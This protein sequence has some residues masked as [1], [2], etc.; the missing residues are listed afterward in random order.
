[1]AAIDKDYSYKVYVDDLPIYGFFGEKETFLVDFGDHQH[2]VTR[3]FLYSHMVFTMEFNEHN[4]I[5][6]SITADVDGR[7][8]LKESQTEPLTVDL[9]YSTE[10]EETSGKFADRIS[11]HSNHIWSDQS[12]NI[13]WLSIINSFILVLLLTVFLAIIVLR[14]LRNDFA[15]YSDADDE[16]LPLEGSVDESGWKQ[17][18]GDVFRFPTRPM[19]FSALI[20]N[21]THLFTWLC[22][23]LLASLSGAF[24]I[25][26]H[27]GFYSTA[28]LAFAVT[29]PIAGFVSA[30][31]YAQIAG[32]QKWATNAV[33]TAGLFF[34]P[35]A[36]VFL[37]LNMV[38]SAYGSLVAV[39]FF[40]V[41]GLILL[42]MLVVFPLTVV[43]AMRGRTLAKPFDA[44]CKTNRVQR[45]IPPSPWYQTK[46]ATGFM[47]GFLPFSAIYIGMRAVRLR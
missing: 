26:S 18:H 9:T 38:A 16:L 47:G 20:G 12:M 45:E 25:D 46:L 30:Y 13:H 15:R 33:L 8:E 19:L 10:W 1:M 34:A 27:G 35:L 4:V 29:A 41:F 44:P 32:D 37:T 23:L 21:G 24:S 5:T 17:V 40:T 36:A 22:I 11:L 2:N 28:I 7:V 43:G 39:P 42:W 3:Y 31:L 14:V 6:A